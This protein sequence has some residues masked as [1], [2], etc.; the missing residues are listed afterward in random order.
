MAT[1]KD[2]YT[3]TTLTTKSVLIDLSGATDKNTLTYKSGSSAFVATEKAIPIG[4]IRM[5]AK[6]VSVSSDYLLC[7]GTTKNT[8]TYAALHA[9]ISNK[10]GGTAY[11]ANVTDVSGANT[12]FTL[13]NFTTPTAPYGQT[14]DTAN[15][16]ATQTSSVSSGNTAQ[17]MDHTHTVPMNMTAGSGSTSHNHNSNNQDVDHTHNWGDNSNTSAGHT[18]TINSNSNQH[19][20]NYSRSNTAGNDVTSGPS[21]NHSHGINAPDTSHTHTVDT[22]GTHTHNTTSAGGTHTGTGNHTFAMSLSSTAVTHT[23]TQNAQSF[24]FYIKAF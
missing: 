4:V 23:H 24:V 19:A 2:F 16:F 20:H 3:P 11:S 15:T 9:V 5:F 14:A 18:H 10:Y 13:P 12:T 8:Y 22:G 1:A 7:D 21:G 17:T 6:G